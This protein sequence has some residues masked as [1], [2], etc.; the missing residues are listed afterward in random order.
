[1]ISWFVI[2]FIATFLAIIR[3]RR[4]GE[5][6]N[7]YELYGVLIGVIAGYITL[8]LLFIDFIREY[9]KPEFEEKDNDIE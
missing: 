3:F 8:A 6:R 5:T 2:G 7:K 9:N 1:M 4:N